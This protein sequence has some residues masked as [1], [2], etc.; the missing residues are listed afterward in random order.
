MRTITYA[1]GDIHGCLDQM[2]EAAAWAEADAASRGAQGLVVF[3][4]DYVDRGTDAPGVIDAL[5]A[6][7]VAGHM[8]W[9]PLRGNHDDMLAKVWADPSHHLA[10]QWW[11][12]GGQQ[13][14]MNYGWNPLE[15]PIPA[16][17][18]EW[19]PE[20]HARFLAGLPLC[21]EDED[22]I[23]VHA[24]LRGGIPLA[25]QEEKDMLWIRSEFLNSDWDFGR[26]VVHG[27]TPGRRN[28]AVTPTRINMD[29]G[30]F[31]TGILA[32]GA[33]EPGVHEPRVRLTGQG[34]YESFVRG[35][36]FC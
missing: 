23:Y 19:I 4:G 11:E 25:E 6:G 13:T 32:C 17:L 12:H 35:R 31:V 27:H 29:T 33:F 14:L 7:P 26:T 24:G 15:H 36:E 18:G 22:R 28:P 8:R 16:H 21:H 2:L 1:I 9:L 20:R 5:M 3:L 34:P 10:G 30:C